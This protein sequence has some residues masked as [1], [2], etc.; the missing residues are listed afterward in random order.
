[1]PSPFGT[2]WSHVSI[3]IAIEGRRGNGKLTKPVS[4]AKVGGI[5]I[6]DAGK[7]IASF[8]ASL[9][10]AMRQKKFADRAQLFRTAHGM[11]AIA[12]IVNDISEK[13]TTT[14]EATSKE[15]L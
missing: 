8:F 14:E 1:V 11:Y 2:N 9:E 10:G 3:K 5:N 15:V 7:Q 12:V 13:R 6:E 4:N